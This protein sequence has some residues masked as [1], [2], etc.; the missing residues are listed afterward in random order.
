MFE[1][2]YPV[3]LSFSL[4]VSLSLLHLDFCREIRV[5]VSSLSSRDE[6]RRDVHESLFSPRRERNASERET[7]LTICS[8]F[9]LLSLSPLTPPSPSLSPSF[10]DFL[11]IK[12]HDTHIFVHRKGSRC[13]FLSPLSSFL[14]LDT[15][16]Y[17]RQEKLLSQFLLTLRP[18]VSQKCLSNLCAFP[19]H[20]LTKSQTCLHQ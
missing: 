4:S 20:V 16:F 7:M 11:Y 10:H 3:I 12:V 17:P 9:R 2:V 5:A 19:S 1:L 14:S 18:D 6:M 8:L 13:F 15:F